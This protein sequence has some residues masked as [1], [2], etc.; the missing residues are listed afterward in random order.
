MRAALVALLML[1]AAPPAAARDV[2]GVQVPDQLSVTGEKKPLTLNL[3][4]AGLRKKY[5]LKVYVGALYTVQPVT[6]ADQVLDATTPRVMRLHFVR[7]VSAAKQ[8]DGWKDGLADNHSKFE[9]KA[10]QT[11]LT[12][13]NAMMLD[14]KENDVLRIDFLPKGVT[15]VTINDKPRGSVEGGDFQRAL[16][17][18]WLG[19]KPADSDLKQALLAGKK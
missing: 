19:A 7:E 9:M 8:A 1:V 11:R 3:N 5:M 12:Q 6:K 4:G 14:V 15:R 13:F 18:I 10:F 17:R 2:D 16:L